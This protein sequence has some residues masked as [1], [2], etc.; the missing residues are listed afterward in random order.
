MPEEYQKDCESSQ[1][2]QSNDSLRTF[3]LARRHLLL[4]GHEC[5]VGIL[6]SVTRYLIV[7]EILSS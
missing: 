4:R 3:D 6:V 2:V 1:E 7:L 5:H